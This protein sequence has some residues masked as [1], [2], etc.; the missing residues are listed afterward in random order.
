MSDDQIQ[1]S[2]E[3]RGFVHEWFDLLSDHVPVELLLPFV[4]DRGLEMAFPERTL[5]DHDDFRDWYTAVGL[6][7]TRQTHDVERISAEEGPDGVDLA[8]TVVWRAEQTDGPPVAVRVDQDW[9]LLRLADGSLRIAGYQVGEM[10]DV[11]QGVD[12][13]VGTSGS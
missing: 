7:Y 2:S 3:V 10:H 1:A 6:A 9:R 12:S 13:G 5:H 11:E 8:V 4:A